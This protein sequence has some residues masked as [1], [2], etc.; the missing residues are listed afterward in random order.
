MIVDV[1]CGRACDFEPGAD[2]VDPC[3]T[4]V[5]AGQ[6][7][8]HR[9]KAQHHLGFDRTGA[10]SEDRRV[11]RNLAV[12]FGDPQHGSRDPLGTQDLDQGRRNTPDLPAEHWRAQRGN[13][14]LLH[15]IGF[16]ECGRHRRGKGGQRASRQPCAQ[17]RRD[18]IRRGR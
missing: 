16:G 10:A 15:R 2:L 13:Q 17:Q 6:P 12:E 11:A 4:I 14:A 8:G 1:G 3:G 5:T 18:R 7:V 9:A